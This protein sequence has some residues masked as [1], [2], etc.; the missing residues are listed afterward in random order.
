[1]RSEVHKVALGHIFSEYFD[2]SCQFS[3]H[4]ML[5]TDLSSGDGETGQLVA[6]VPSLARLDEKNNNNEE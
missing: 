2:F 4:K 6:D 1:V 5:H 3:F